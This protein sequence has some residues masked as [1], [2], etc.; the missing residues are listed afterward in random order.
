[1]D[2][3][4]WLLSSYS[5]G[6]DMKIEDLEIGK[7]YWRTH[8]YGQPDQIVEITHRNPHQEEVGIVYTSDDCTKGLRMTMNRIECDRYLDE[9]LPQEKVLADKLRS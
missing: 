4:R 2:E 7:E 5:K 6:F 9:I 8:A 3:G 1:M